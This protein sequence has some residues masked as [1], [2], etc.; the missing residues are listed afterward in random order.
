MAKPGRPK[1]EQR[2]IVE[3]M[4]VNTMRILSHEGISHKYFAEGGCSFSTVIKSIAA[5]R[6]WGLI[7]RHLPDGRVLV[8]RYEKGS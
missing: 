5:K 1:S 2:K 3:R 8:G 7:M 4:R 6:G